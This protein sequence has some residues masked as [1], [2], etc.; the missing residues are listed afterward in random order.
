M[1]FIT[2]MSC[3]ASLQQPSQ[4]KSFFVKKCLY[5]SQN[6]SSFSLQEYIGRTLDMHKVGTLVCF[7]FNS[8]AVIISTEKC[9]L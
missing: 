3:L 4:I 9:Y 8:N 2:A 1:I 5:L 6:S 7:I